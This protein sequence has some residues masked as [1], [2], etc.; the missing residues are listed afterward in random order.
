VSR[1]LALAAITALL[2]LYF[3]G[4]PSFGLIGPDEPRYASIGRE[5]ALSGDWITPRL[6]G[7]PWFEKPAMLYWMIAGAFRLGLGPDIAPRL[8]VALLSIAF[9]VVFFLW[10]RRE[11]NPF[12]GA[13]SA[14]LLATSAMWFSYSH[15]AVTDIPMAVTFAG[16]I[17]LLLPS[18][19]GRPAHSVWA[20]VL[21]ALSFLSKGLVP[22]VLILPFFWF[23]RRH[24]R[25]WLRPAAIPVFLIVALPWYIA[26]TWRNGPAFLNTFF[27][28]HTFGRFSSDA[29]QHVQPFWFY[30]PWMLAAL[31]PSILLAAFAASR[32]LYRDRRRRFLLVL[33]VFGLVFFSASRNKLPGYL[34]PLIPF[35]CILMACGLDAA[36]ELWPKP[37]ALVTAGSILLIPLFA[38]AGGLLPLAAGPGLRDA[39]PVDLITAGRVADAIPLAIVAAIASLVMTRER[40]LILWFTLVFCGWAYIEYA[41]LP[42]VD[43][44]ASARSVW[45]SLPEPK[46]QFCV[47]AVSRTWRYGLNYYSVTPLPDCAPGVTAHAILPGSSGGA[48]PITKP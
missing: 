3:S 14:C 46:R 43:R 48:Q 47:G 11:F 2:F 15:A 17:M 36:R 23:A 25:A 22:L 19:E 6:W 31:F 26:C 33:V 41:A 9:L 16:A 42:W 10:A 8:P 27:M 40:A 12:V 30:L 7:S 32:V 24:W 45:A 4:L 29:M 28:Q 37:L 20:A 18:V 39:F 21:L 35:A 34:L 44:M 1:L 5:M 38:L 13:V